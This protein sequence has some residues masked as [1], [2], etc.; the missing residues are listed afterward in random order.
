MPYTSLLRAGIIGLL[1]A[2]FLFWALP[3]WMQASGSWGG[4]EVSAVVFWFFT[5]L[6]GAGCYLLFRPVVEML[7]THQK[8]RQRLRMFPELPLR[9]VLPWRRYHATAVMK[10]LPNF[11]FIYGAVLWILIFLF[12]IVDQRYPSH[13]L[14]IDLRTN[15]FVV[16]PKSP[17]EETLYVYLAPGPRF[18]INGQPVE[19]DALRAKLQIELGHRAVWMVYFEGHPD[20]LS[21]DALYAMDAIQSLGAKVIWLTPKVREQLRA[22][23]K[24]N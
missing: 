7:F 19:R 23:A 21:V 22:S 9:N 5:S 3:I 24:L 11:G 13:G 6:A 16:G 8:S 18:Y 2:S 10:E 15:A 4:V 1:V 20:A 12:M 14:P 17:S